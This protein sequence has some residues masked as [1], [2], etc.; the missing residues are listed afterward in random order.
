MK[1][2]PQQQPDAEKEAPADN[3]K[4]QDKAAVQDQ[5]KASAAAGAAAPEAVASG[6]SIEPV[7]VADTPEDGFPNLFRQLSDGSNHSKTS[8]SSKS[9]KSS[10]ASKLSQKSEESVK[11]KK[12][13][14]PSI[15][16]AAKAL[17]DS[18]SDSDFTEDEDEHAFDHPST[19]VDQPWIWVPKD[20]LGLSEMLISDLKLVGV[21]AS[22]VGAEM[23]EKGIVEV[24]RNPPDEDWSGGHD[25]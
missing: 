4:T 17:E 16:P 22:N 20:S 14:P 7:P 24:S 9:S 6:S 12:S 1:L 11:S 23:D 3:N 18:D 15:A 21:D 19:Y 10:K 25:Q 2:L 8:V 5:E 13:G